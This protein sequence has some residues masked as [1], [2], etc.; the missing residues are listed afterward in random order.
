MENLIQIVLAFIG[1]GVLTTI[2]TYFVSK[3]KYAA[4]VE[5]LK[6]QIDAART[7]DRIK[8]DEHI[9]AQFM[10]IAES[11]KAETA[12]RKQEIDELRKENAELMVQIQGFQ[13]QINEL[14]SQITQLMNWIAY[15][16]LHY[17]NWLEKELLKFDPNIQF[18]NYRRAP[19]FV[20]EYLDTITTDNE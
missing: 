1:S 5:A 2:V 14:N 3:K 9:Q 11:Y 16:M 4:E 7:D 6:Q 12:A 18:P 10:E 17:K 8:I 15:D 13:R 19:K 20:R